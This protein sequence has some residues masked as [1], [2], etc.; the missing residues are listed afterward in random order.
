[1]SAPIWLGPT[2]AEICAVIKGGIQRA[3]GDGF[4]GFVLDRDG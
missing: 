3:L 2:E 4:L 1:M